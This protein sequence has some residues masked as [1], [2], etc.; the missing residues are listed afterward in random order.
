MTKKIRWGVLGASRI[1][2]KVI[3]SIMA[4]PNCEVV[5]VASRSL[6]KAQAYANE[7]GIPKAFGSYEEMLAS[8]EIDAVYNPLPND[9][10]AKWSI[11]AAEHGL[12]VLCEKPL[13]L[14]ANE[15]QQLVDAFDSRGLLL[16][17]AFMWRFHPQHAVVKDLIDSGAI[18]EVK[19]MNGT[20]TFALTRDSDIRLNEQQGGGSLMDVGCYPINA[21]R[22]ILGEEPDGGQAFAQFAKDSNLD[23]AVSAVLSFPSGVLANLD[24][25]FTANRTNYYDI[26]GSHGRIRV[27]PA[28]IPNSD[29][30]TTI[31]VWRGENDAE[32]EAI[33]V[34]PANQ[35]THMAE[36]FADALLNQRPFRFP[37]ED[38]VKN[39]LVIDNLLASA[40]GQTGYW[41]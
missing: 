34:E 18:G 22:V 28:F 40:K 10:H 31:Q 20:F 5:A 17:E 15:A 29:E 30:V 25:G 39:M 14:N 32:Y 38:A 6:D 19:L 35:Y 4:A 36:D 9:L 37:V 16:A 8:G 13:A 2:R 27:E 23:L 24:C 12:A 41:S 21:M 11:A 26:R 33:Q 1:G 3:P 7:L